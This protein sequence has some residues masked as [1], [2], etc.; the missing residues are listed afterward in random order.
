MHRQ[1]IGWLTACGLTAAMVFVA[2][3]MPA[4]PPADKAPPPTPNDAP[5]TPTTGVKGVTSRVVA[6]TVYQNSALVTREVEVPNGP[7]LLELTVTPLPPTTV[8]SSLY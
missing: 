4:N 3:H 7:G 8:N 5:A 6:V 2:T 1:L